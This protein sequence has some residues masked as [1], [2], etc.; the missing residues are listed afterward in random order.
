LVGD[1][2]RATQSR[3]ADATSAC[4][5][6]V[7]W[8]RDHGPMGAATAPTVA[9]PV[10]GRPRSAY[11]DNLKVVLVVGVIVGHVLIT[12]GDIGTWSYREPS[13]N[14]AFLIPAA[15]F[16]SLGSLFAMG[17]FFLIAGLLSPRALERK[18]TS[19]FLRDRTLRLGLPFLVF[20]LLA[21]PL[22]KWAGA[23][24]TRPIDEYLRSQLHDLDPGPLWFVIVL[25]LFSVMYAGWRSVR[26][27]SETRRPFKAR[28]LVG[29]VV[30]ISATTFIT[31]LWLPIDS[32]QPLEAHVWQWPQCLGMFALG[33]ACGE[34]GWLQPVPDRLRRNAGCAA[35]I[36][37]GAMIGAFAVSSD[38]I[39]PFAGGMSWQAMLVALCE[40]VVAVGLGVWM[41]GFFQ[42]HFDHAGP[43]AHAMGRAAFGAYVLQAVVVVGLAVAASFLP[44]A[45]EYKALLI[46]PVAVI[47]SFGL[48]WLLT[49]VPGVRR[50]V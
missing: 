48:A 14:N 20:M 18:G 43:L 25:L 12:Y 26:E 32:H 22:V 45:A 17:V 37:L 1:G 36:G 38:S 13:G 31:R 46:A 33:I 7:E 19:G 39:D 49:L 34:N 15:M 41:V 5:A 11:L 21:Y 28:Y 4:L 16:V 24:G 50:V 6:W 40:G 8:R 27:P 47:G 10:A 9:T 35:L 44:L 42:R 2:T 29:L 23:K 3:E 30:V